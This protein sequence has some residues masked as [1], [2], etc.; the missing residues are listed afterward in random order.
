MIAALL[1]LACASKP[2]RAVP[3]PVQ[4]SEEAI[5]REA[6]KL[7]AG[8]AALPDAAPAE[9]PSVVLIVLDTTRADLLAAYGG[10]G[11]MPRLDAFAADSRVY[12]RMR[13][14]APWTLPS[15]ASLFTGLSSLE[16][17][18]VGSP[19]G[20]DFAAYGLR[21]DVPTLA[22]RLGEAGWRTVGI[23]ANKAFLA[24]EWGLLRGFQLWACERLSAGVTRSY[25]QGD[26]IT[27]LART[28]LEQTP[29]DRPL[30]LFLN[31]ME[32]H[33]PWTPRE[34]YTAHPDRI[35]PALLPRGPGFWRAA[36][37]QWK[38]VNDEI[39][40]GS[41]D[42]T[43]EELATWREAYQAEARFLDERL[44]QL[45]DALAAAGHGPEDY[46]IIL[47]DHGEFLGEHRLIEHSKD[48]YEEALRVPLIVRGPGF[49]PGV[50]DGPITTRDV[51]E[52]LLA[53]LGL[54]PLSAE[55]PR[56]ALQVAELY[57]TRQKNLRSPAM[58]ARFNRVRRAFV[59]GD[60]KLILSSDGQDEAYD[61]AKDPQEQSSILLSA[62]WVTE[63][64]ALA[65][66]WLGAH[67]AGQGEPLRLSAEQ[68]ERLEALGYVDP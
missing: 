1:A 44:G 14:T 18:A 51:P 4:W 29:P 23:A 34:G 12:T 58:L 48:V 43:P 42:A 54:A 41:R 26:V 28:A 65:E 15:H 24:S 33:T 30:F 9:R 21:A 36:P 45:F 3:V 38:R 32:P 8:L 52:L 53:A 67:T 13:S 60:H 7:R 55:P 6:P 39:L 31:F 20:S 57:Y 37:G 35:N 2:D 62:P 5:E 50:D 63:L 68:A 19:P 46:T 17:G 66:A 59:L 40:S 11:L 64:R 47:G 25:V 10:G 61:L 16:H 22:E 56:P 27:A 49:A